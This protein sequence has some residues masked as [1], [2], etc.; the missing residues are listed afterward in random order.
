MALAD[1]CAVV[2]MVGFVESFNISG[3]GQACV[4]GRQAASVH[5]AGA[6]NP[7][8]SCRLPVPSHPAH[9]VLRLPSAAPLP[10]CLALPAVQQ[11]LPL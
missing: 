10:P 9:P 11:W 2:P 3:Q 7:R 6:T 5:A 8:H 1:A 4:R